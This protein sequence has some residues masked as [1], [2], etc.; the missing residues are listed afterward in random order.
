MI[1]VFETS[2]LFLEYSSDD[3]KKGFLYRCSTLQKFIEHLNSN[4]VNC[5]ILFTKE[6]FITLKSTYIFTSFHYS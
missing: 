3:G 2:L 1:N 4:K 5:F 6:N